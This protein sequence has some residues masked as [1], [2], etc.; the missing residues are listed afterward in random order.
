MKILKYKSFSEN[1]Q[2]GPQEEGPQGQ[3]REEV[4]GEPDFREIEVPGTD[5]NLYQ[6]EQRL[7]PIKDY[8]LSSDGTQ[9]T[10]I[11]GKAIDQVLRDEFPEGEFPEGEIVK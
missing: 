8:E 11:N 9:V 3:G 6:F 2:V 5:L 1:L 10:K 4:Q 7:G